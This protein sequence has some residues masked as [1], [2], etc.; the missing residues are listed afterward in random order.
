MLI[1]DKYRESAC[2]WLRFLHRTNS[3]L[4]VAQYYN[5]NAAK[6]EL[7]KSEALFWLKRLM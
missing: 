2:L 1:E 6:C 3:S 4:F 7:F 5:D